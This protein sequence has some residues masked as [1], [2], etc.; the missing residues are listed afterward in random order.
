MDL[1][2]SIPYSIHK[3]VSFCVNTWCDSA[4][5]D[6]AVSYWQYGSAAA[7]DNIYTVSEL[8]RISFL[9]GANLTFTAVCSSVL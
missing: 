1:K 5:S 7:R 6:S 8:V 3:H 2:I 4:Q 9:S